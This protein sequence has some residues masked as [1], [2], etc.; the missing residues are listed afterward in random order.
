ERAVFMEKGEVRFS[1]PTSDLLERDDI[2][3]S[4]FLEGAATATGAKKEPAAAR[5]ERVMNDAPVVLELRDVSRT[6]GGIRA[7]DEV[8][9]QLHRNEILGLIG[10]NGAGKTTLFDL[11]SGFL[12][13]DGGHILF[14]GDEQSDSADLP[15]VSAR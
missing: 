7:V 1:G 10:P 6:F 4:V 8:S 12:P 11:V 15:D 13:T 14:E 3:R 5:R 9:L 2:L